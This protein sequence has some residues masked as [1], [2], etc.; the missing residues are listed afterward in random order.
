MTHGARERLIDWGLVALAVALALLAVA[1]HAP[2]H[3]SMDSSEQ[4]YEAATGRSVSWSPPFMSALLHWLGGGARATTAFVAACAALTYGG[5]VLAALAGRRSRPA[6]F[7]LVRGLAILVLIANPLVFLHVGIV[8]KDVLLAGLLATSGGLLLVAAHGDGGRRSLA[9]ALAL[10]ALVPLLLVRQQGVVLAPAL[11]ATAAGL[12]A[13]PLRDPGS[14][15]WWLRWA[16]VVGL[17]GLLCAGTMH[18]VRQAIEE[19][20]DKSTA[21]GLAAVQRYDLAGMLATGVAPREGLPPGLATPAFTAAVKRAYS[22]DRIDFVLND[23]TVVAGFHGLDGPTVAR[24]FGDQVRARPGTYLLVKARQFG[25]LLGLYRI[26]RCLPLHVGVEGNPEYLRAAGVA[27][28]M[29]RHDQ[30]LYQTGLL[31]RQLVL[32][33]HWFYLSLLV[34]ACLYL[35]ATRRSRPAAA[36]TAAGAVGIALLAFYGAY[37]MTTIACDFRYLYPGL[38]GT[39]VLAVYLLAAG[40]GRPATVSDP[41]ARR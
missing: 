8:W 1:A 19:S 29:D 9:A 28:G 17:Y 3:V 16:A 26:D 35:W 18:A 27:Q 38:V 25:W 10:V 39:S 23:P 36:T 34:I 15:R 4:L 31:A 20:G 11:V 14:A 24:V 21:V 40:P 5:I 13:G 32:Y 6:R 12:L 2:G 37:A 22:A 33:R 7:G 41:G 30:L